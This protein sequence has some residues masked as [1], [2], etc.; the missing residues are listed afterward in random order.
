MEPAASPATAQPRAGG[1]LRVGIVG[2]IP[3]LDPHQLGGSVADVLSPIWDR[4]ME[5]GP[6]TK[7]RPALAEGWDLSR[8][9]TQ[10]EL[11]L[12]RGVTFHTGRELTSDAVAPAGLLD[13]LRQDGA[14][15]CLSHGPR[16]CVRV[17]TASGPD[18]IY[19]DSRLPRWLPRHLRAHPM[20]ATAGIRP[21]HASRVAP[22]SGLQGG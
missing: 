8:D 1:T 2:D 6:Q 5:Y 4:L 15:V 13:R 14:V 21:L 7:P 19:L 22:D 16:G 10:L 18:T 17:A 20:T 3:S 12:R 9:G 11:S